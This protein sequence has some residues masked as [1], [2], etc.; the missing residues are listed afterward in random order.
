M[1]QKF[2]FFR[3]VE[4]RVDEIRGDTGQDEEH[5]ESQG[6]QDYQC[7]DTPFKY[8]HGPASTIFILSGFVF[9]C[10]FIP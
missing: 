1:S 9:C 10:M 5:D 8:V 3:G 4:Y 6:S 2:Q 7:Y